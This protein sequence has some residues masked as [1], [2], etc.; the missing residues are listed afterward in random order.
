MKREG[1]S[2]SRRSFLKG[3]AGALGLMATT[4]LPGCKNPNDHLIPPE[5]VERQKNPPVPEDWLGTPPEI[6]DS[7]L[8]DTT[9]ADVVI[10][11]AGVAGLFAARAAAEAGASVIVVEKAATWQWRS[12]QYGTIGNKFQKQLGIT[13]DK[14]AA[15]NENMKQMGYRADQRAWNYWADHSG[16]DFDWMVALAPAVHVM[17]ETDTDLQRDKINLQFSHYP[18]PPEYRR[19]EENSP[20]YPTVMTFLPSQKPMLEL[21]VKRCLDL[22]VTFVYSTR[23]VK[24]LRPKQDEK[25]RVDGVI[26]E[27]LKGQYHRYRAR[28]AVILCTGDYGGN[29]SMIRHFVP[30]AV[31]YVN[32]YPNLDAKNQP[33]NTGDGHRMGAWIGGKIEDGPHAPMIHTLGGPLGVNAYLLVNQRGH[34]FVNEDNGGQQ[35][36]CALYRQPD[37]F[38]WQIFDD[39]WSEQLP[40]MGVSHGSV[41][42]CVEHNPKLPLDCQWTVGRTSY[43]SR[44]DLMQTPGLITANSL[45]ELAGKLFPDNPRAQKNLL[46]TIARY[47][48]LA[49]AHS[50]ADFGKAA[51]RLFPIRT[52]PFYAGKMEGGATLVTMGGF[53]IDPLTA[54]VLDKDYDPIPGLY[55][56]G[57]TQGCRF[58]GD[59][60]VVTAGVSHG[61]ALVYGRLAGTQAAQCAPD[62]IGKE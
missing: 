7:K 18:T 53:T 25:G 13:F 55:A 46:A 57:N 11:G 51:K 58:V 6:P 37:N 12:G 49:D 50:D 26:G 1:T 45:E 31:D 35:L 43:T 8:A 21:V 39:K 3:G 24:L 29:K 20:S 2:L 14:N 15:I 5:E 44:E 16:E 17:Q 19:A 33:A 61:F 54:N 23:A 59:Y 56:A 38:G 9:E 52:A 42:H 22:G 10:V 30:W 4:L 62:A 36:S 40:F 41:N 48:E 28:R 32:V 34:R 60:P 47:N 27:D